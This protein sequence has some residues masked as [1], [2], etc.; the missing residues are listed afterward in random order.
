MPD[1][2]DISLGS[3]A[4]SAI[5]ETAAG[6]AFVGYLMHGLTSG[7]TPEAALVRASAAGAL[8]VTAAGA[9]P[10]IPDAASV[11]RFLGEN[12]IRPPDDC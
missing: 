1:G 3:F 4:V 7:L 8:T 10:S 5:D 6:D 2:L 11:S 12:S 9:A